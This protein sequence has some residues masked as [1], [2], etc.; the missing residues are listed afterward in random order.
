VLA[1]SCPALSQ[2]HRLPDHVHGLS[3][4]LAGAGGALLQH[5]VDVAGVGHD[6]GAALPVGRQLGD[7]DLGEL[8]LVGDTAELAGFA[9]ALC[10]GR[11]L[12]GI[13][14]A[15]GEDW[16]LGSL[17]CAKGPSGSSSWKT[18]R[19]GPGRST[20]RKPANGRKKPSC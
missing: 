2:L 18:W 5:A 3:G 10:L 15:V 20:P 16:A 19:L 11:R 14:L 17:V 13:A 7:E 12:G 4:F 1:G 6:G 9:A 8:L